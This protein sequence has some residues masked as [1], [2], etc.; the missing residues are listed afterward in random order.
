[1]LVIIIVI[2]GVLVYFIHFRKV[3]CDICGNEVSIGATET[4]GN[5]IC[6][7]ECLI[8][9]KCDGLITYRKDFYLD[10]V[11]EIIF[12]DEYE[13]YFK[14]LYNDKRLISGI[15]NKT[16]KYI[17]ANGVLISPTII[18]SSIYANVAVRTNEIVAVTMEEDFFQKEL[19]SGYKGYIVTFFTKNKFI[20]FLFTYVTGADK[21]FRFGSTQEKERRSKLEGLLNSLFNAG[22]ISIDIPYSSKDDL[23]EY[24]ND[25]NAELIKKGIF[26]DIFTKDM[27]LQNIKDASMIKLKDLFD[28]KTENITQTEIDA[29]E[30]IM[31]FGYDDCIQLLE[32]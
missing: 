20:P 23:K 6:C 7:Q 30:I 28:K 25:N 32:L 21:F 5:K 8:N 4:I 3:K 13:E 9:K 17:M 14:D 10:E 27:F 19:K 1:M 15:L 26:N 11:R 18:I 24:I 2:I 16:K 29:G 12:L 31:R 22:H